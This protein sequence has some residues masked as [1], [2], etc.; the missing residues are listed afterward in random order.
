VQLR[1]AHERG[2]PIAFRATAEKGLAIT[3]ADY[4]KSYEARSKL[5]RDMARW[6]RK[7]DLLLAPV[8]PTSAPPVETLY[9]SDAFPRWTKGAPY[10]LPFNLTGQPAASMPAGLTPLG[11]PVGIQIVGPARADALV[12]SAMRAYESAA[13]WTWPQA[14]LAGTLVIP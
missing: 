7:Y 8:T 4:A 11:L 5:A 14:R 1:R 10:T 2:Q 3:L 12:L 6:H 9:N 13:G